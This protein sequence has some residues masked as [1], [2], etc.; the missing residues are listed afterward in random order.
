VRVF[1]PREEWRVADFWGISGC[2]VTLP[3]SV[4]GK[5]FL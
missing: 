4:R 5:K 1:K 2:D 3:Y